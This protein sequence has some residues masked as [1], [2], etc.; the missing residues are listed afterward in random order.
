MFFKN[1]KNHNDPSGP[2]LA[3]EVVDK[4]KLISLEI[5]INHP[6]KDIAH[7]SYGICQESAVK[8]QS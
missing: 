3:F 2:L 7:M 6:K 5:C 4:V 8:I 1:I